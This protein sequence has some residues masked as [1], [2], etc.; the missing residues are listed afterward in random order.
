MP[1]D[2]HVYPCPVPAPYVSAR[3]PRR[4]VLLALSKAFYNFLTPLERKQ[5]EGRKA[6]W[7]GQRDTTSEGGVPP[8]HINNAMIFSPV[9]FSD[10]YFWNQIETKE[11]YNVDTPKVWTS[12]SLSALIFGCQA[13]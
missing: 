6:A 8:R 11:K 5:S 7:C 2:F 9:E 1:N 3:R 10:K 4:Y 13:D 12:S